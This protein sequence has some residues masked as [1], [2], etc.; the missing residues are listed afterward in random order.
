MDNKTAVKMKEKEI[1][2]IFKKTDALLEGHFLLSSGLHSQY[3]VQ[4]AKVLQYPEYAE[5]LCKELAKAFKKEKVDVVIG[6]ALGGIVISYELARQL[7]TKS[8]FTERDSLGKMILRRNFSLHPTD[9]VLA[10]EDVITTAGSV[11]EVIELVKETGA[12]V[13]GVACL[14]DRTS[15]ESDLEIK[16]LIKLDFPLY[17]EA[18]CPFC[19]KGIPFIKPGSRLASK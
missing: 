6:P 9:R 11:K 16:S 3:Y 2:D 15:K 4:C 18:S 12:K 14:V 10:V 13:I 1:L 19:K 17:D 5:M 7:K 8:L